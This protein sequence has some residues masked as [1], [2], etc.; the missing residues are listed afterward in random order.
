MKQAPRSALFG[1]DLNVALIMING[2]FDLKTPVPRTTRATTQ[3]L[4]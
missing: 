2:Y 1:A 4:S 3:I